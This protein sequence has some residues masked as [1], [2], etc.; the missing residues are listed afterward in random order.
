MHHVGC[1][2]LLLSLPA[3]SQN[4][5]HRAMASSP[6]Q[7]DSARFDAKATRR[8]MAHCIV[9]RFKSFNFNLL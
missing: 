5:R 3:V 4:R 2:L 7:G 1:R 6:D 9:K 8:G